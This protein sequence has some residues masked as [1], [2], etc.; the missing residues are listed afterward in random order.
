MFIKIKV[1]TNAAKNQ[2]IKGTQEEFI[3]KVTASPE[4]GKAN[5]KAI[6][7]LAEYFAVS[8]TKVLIIK[9]EY[10]SKKVINILK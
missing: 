4:R 6:E 2:I 9:G 3:V 8:R 5:K 1:I 7:L 10:N